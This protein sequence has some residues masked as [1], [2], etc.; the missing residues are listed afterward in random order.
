[1]PPALDVHTGI[2]AKGDIRF[3]APDGNLGLVAFDNVR[4]ASI[5]FCS[6]SE[7]SDYEIKQSSRFITRIAIA[8]PPHISVL[9]HYL[10]ELRT[11][12]H[13]VFL[14]SYRGLR[15]DGMYRRRLD[16]DLARRIIYYA[17]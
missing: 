13:D 17:Q 7:I 11:Q 4:E 14:S 12:T 3:N 5:R 6:I 1:M 9:N 2:G 15:K 16:W 10:N 8:E